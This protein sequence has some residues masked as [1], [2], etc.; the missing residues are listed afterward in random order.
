MSSLPAVAERIAQAQPDRNEYDHGSLRIRAK[1]LVIG[2]SIYPI[3][4]IARIT[5]SDLRRPIPQYVWIMLAFCVVCLPL[6]GGATAVGVLLVALAGYLVYQT[7]L[8]RSAAD[9]SLAIQMNSG[10][11][12]MVMSNKGDFLKAI[13]LE[14]YEVIELNKPSNTTFNIDQK[15]MIDNATGTTIRITGI[16]GDIV[17]NVGP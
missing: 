15:L 5:F 2:N 11:T 9:Y 4:N 3:E 6:G 7:W 1:T 16:Q 17:N 8:S 13:A 14:L 10:N 12:A